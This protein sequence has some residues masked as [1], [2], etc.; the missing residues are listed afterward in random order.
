MDSYLGFFAGRV[1]HIHALPVPGHE[2]HGPERLAA[3][4]T[5]WGIACTAHD[6]PTAAIRAIA[7]QGDAAPKILIGGSLYLAGEILRLNDQ[8]PD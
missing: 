4:A 3:V 2:H 8:L 6:E 7:A 1:A 5:Q